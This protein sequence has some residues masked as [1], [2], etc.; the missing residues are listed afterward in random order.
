MRSSGRRPALRGGLEADPAAETR[1]LYRELLAVEPDTTVLEPR[2]LPAE[3][4]SFIGREQ[5]LA[6]IAG[7]LAQTRLLTLTGPGGSG[8]TRLAVAAAARAA[9]AGRDAVVFVELGPIT[10]PELVGD[11][12]ADAFGFLMPAKSTAADALAAQIAGLRALVVL[13]T[14]E[15]LVDACAALAEVLLAR[16]PE[17]TILATSRE[18]LRAAG[19][20]AWPVPGCRPTRHSSCSSRAHVTLILPSRRRARRSRRSRRCARAWRGCRWR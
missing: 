6:A 7:E 13:D 8:K 14:C 20:R 19:E 11:A 18:R 10:D 5:E 16:C 3:L 2:G 15:H 9:Y 1:A 12:A 4:T 17:L